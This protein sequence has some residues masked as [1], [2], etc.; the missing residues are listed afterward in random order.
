MNLGGYHQVKGEV[1]EGH[2]ENLEGYAVTQC[3]VK[4]FIEVGGCL[5]KIF[6]PVKEFEDFTN[7]QESN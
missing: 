3:G 5:R 6:N 1:S 7:N 2:E 4:R